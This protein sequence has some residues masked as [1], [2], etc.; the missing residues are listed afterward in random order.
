PSILQHERCTTRS[1]VSPECRP[2][3]RP[4]ASSRQEAQHEAG[5]GDFAL[6]REA[7]A[8]HCFF[9]E[10]GIETIAGAH[11]DITDGFRLTEPAPESM[12]DLRLG[13]AVEWAHDPLVSM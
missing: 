10:G 4:T 3:Q 6:F 2:Q 5:H 11:L 9:A 1:G 13:A 7:A 12:F 8:E